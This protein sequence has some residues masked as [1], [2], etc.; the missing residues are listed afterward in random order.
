[1]NW[2]RMKV[3]REVAPGVATLAV[4]SEKPLLLTIKP[5]SYTWPAAV[6]NEINADCP[7]NA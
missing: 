2:T 6:Q 5:G 1:M 4:G 7:A 3:L